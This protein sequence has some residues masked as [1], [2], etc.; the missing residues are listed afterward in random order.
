MN[1]N[2]YTD[3]HA[4][5]YWTLTM[6]LPWKNSDSQ[7]TEKLNSYLRGGELHRNQQ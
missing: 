5:D 4:V 6:H 3:K 2:H 1:E 7:V